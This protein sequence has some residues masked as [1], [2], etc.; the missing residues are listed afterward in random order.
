M[1]NLF[2]FYFVS[3]L[4]FLNRN[5]YRKQLFLYKKEKEFMTMRLLKKASKKTNAY[6]KVLTLEF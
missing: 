3:I 4:H 5:F 1:V 6:Y 2:K